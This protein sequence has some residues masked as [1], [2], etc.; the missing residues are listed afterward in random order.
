[1]T[2]YAVHAQGSDDIIAAPSKDDAQT[3]ADRMNMWSDTFRKWVGPARAV[4]IEYPDS[5]ESHAEQ[6]EADWSRH[7]LF[8]VIADPEALQPNRTSR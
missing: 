4:V 2:L 1:M 8:I 7:E 3:L 5:P 6:L